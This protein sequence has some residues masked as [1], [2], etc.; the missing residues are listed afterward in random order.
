LA[1]TGD[2]EKINKD[3]AQW[4]ARPL[5]KEMSMDDRGVAQRHKS[6]RIPA[7]KAS[8]E[9]CDAQGVFKREQKLQAKNN[10]NAKQTV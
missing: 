10:S 8:G 9:I 2:A 1:W 7:G 3:V 4:K 6:T 5:I